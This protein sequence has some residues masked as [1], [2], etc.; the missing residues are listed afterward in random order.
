MKPCWRSSSESLSMLIPGCTVTVRSSTSIS[1]IR[2]I[3]FTSTRIP[4]RRGTA[5]SVSPV[6]P[7]RGT[8]GI[9][10]RLASLTTSETSSA[11]TGRTTAWGMNSSHRWAGNGDGTR[12]RLKSADLP[13]KTRPSP[14]IATSSSIR[15]SGRGAIT[16]L[17]LES[18]G[19]GHEL[20]DVEDLDSLCLALLV[21]RPLRPGAGRDE[22]VDAGELGGPCDPPPADLRRQVGPLDREPASGPGAVR[23]L[24]HVVDVDEGQARNGSEDFA[25]RLVHAEPLV[26]TTGV[27]VGDR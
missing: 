19:L 20:E 9:R 2:V 16:A 7:A 1:R 18:R 3:S 11:E 15:V 10:A 6:P 13:V 4:C 5:P 14:Q 12:A 23:P 26:Q 25:R 17:H 21:E 22:R 8:T 27:V 24:R